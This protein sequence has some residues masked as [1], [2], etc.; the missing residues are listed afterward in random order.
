MTDR[1]QE[2]TTPLLI[3]NDTAEIDLTDIFGNSNAETE[4]GVFSR[5]FGSSQTS[6]ADSSSSS[7]VQE[8][9]DH[10]HDRDSSNGARA[11][12]MNRN[13]RY[14]RRGALFWHR[15]D[16]GTTEV[17]AGENRPGVIARIQRAFWNCVRCRGSCGQ[18]FCA[19]LGC[20]PCIQGFAF[21]WAIISVIF[22]RRYPTIIGLLFMTWL[23]T[24]L[25][26]IVTRLSF[27]PDNS[28]EGTPNIAY[29]R[30]VRNVYRTRSG[31]RIPWR[32]LA[33]MMNEGNFT[34][35]DYERL[36]ALDE[37]TPTQVLQ[38][39]S[40]H[41]IN[42]LPTY[43]YEAPRAKEQEETTQT[44]GD[45]E[46]PDKELKRKCSICLAYFENGEQLRILPCLHQFHSECI[47]PWLSQ[48]KAECPVCKVDI[49]DQ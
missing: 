42:R 23:I 27:Q 8:A 44:A 35:Q 29:S 46:D 18:C 1:R 2:E 34:D 40:G 5:W 45:E 9:S 17:E 14:S 32:N 15:V 16:D 12:V 37:D 24:F 43:T 33:L 30:H 6:A 49:R 3:N 41:E 38:R 26:A 7:F 48:G 19:A 31:Q 13:T 25:A 36:L 21:C 11:P 20:M 28:S 10:F 39:A 47:D 22:L 4:R